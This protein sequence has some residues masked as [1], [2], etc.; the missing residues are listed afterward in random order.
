MATRERSDL[1]KRWGKSRPPLRPPAQ[2][3]AAMTAELAGHPGE[4]LLLGV[5]PELATATPS[6]TA[7]DWSTEMI[8]Q[9]WPGNAPGRR[10]VEADW[11]AMPLRAGYFASAWGDGVFGML[12]WPDQCVELIAQVERLL[13]PGGRIVL[14]CFATLD[15]RD[16]VEAVVHETLAGRGGGF[17]AFKWR[18]AMALLDADSNVFMR[19]V[20][21]AFE[22]HFPDRERLSEATGW[23]VET[24]A[25]IDD[26]RDASTLKSF[27]SV[28]ALT[29]VFPQSRIVS[30]GDYEMAERCPLLVMDCA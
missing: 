12:R 16:T 15:S 28:H 9:V 4:R 27:P 23:P 7:V 11:L 20:W 25:E 22:R 10:I 30:S 24:I 26:Y 19:D 13:R 18:L 17:H 6:L 3:V 2:A 29:K 1:Y 14:R 21:R 5:T 8:S